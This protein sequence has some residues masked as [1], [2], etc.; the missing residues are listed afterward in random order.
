MIV[1]PP[2]FSRAK[3]GKVFSV[4]RDLEKLLSSVFPVLA[5]Q[6]ILFFSSNLSEWN[7]ENLKKRSSTVLESLGVW[8]WL[9]EI[10]KPMDFKGTQ[11]PLSQ[12]AIQ[13]Y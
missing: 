8:Q 1:D 6:G 13:K 3:S 5:P 4:K 11:V 10:E 12:W 2:S 7:S 9:P